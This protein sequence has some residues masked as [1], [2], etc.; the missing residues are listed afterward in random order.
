MIIIIITVSGIGFVNK[1]NWQRHPHLNLHHP[2]NSPMLH[3]PIHEQQ[4]QTKLMLCQNL[5]PTYQ[6]NQQNQR[7]AV[8]GT[9]RYQTLHSLWT[10]STTDSL[11]GIEKK[12]I[13]AFDD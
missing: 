8:R 5:L 7:E 13:A 6:I 1:Q 9:R 2:L 10:P 3:C 12:T 11:T 4:S